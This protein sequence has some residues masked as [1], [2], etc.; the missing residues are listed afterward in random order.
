MYGVLCNVPHTDG[1]H[2]PTVQ[3]RKADTFLW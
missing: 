2:S 1:G 3:R